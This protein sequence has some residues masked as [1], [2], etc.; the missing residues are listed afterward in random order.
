MAVRTFP[1]FAISYSLG[2]APWWLGVAIGLDSVRFDQ[3]VFQPPELI[4]GVL[5]QSV[6]DSALMGDDRE[7]VRFV[8]SGSWIVP[9]RQL[10]HCLKAFTSPSNTMRRGRA[11]VRGRASNRPPASR[12]MV[13]HAHSA[14]EGSGSSVPCTP[15][16]TL[17]VV[18]VAWSD[19][20][21][22]APEQ[23][24]DQEHPEEDPNQ[25][26]SAEHDGRDYGGDHEQWG[27]PEHS[28]PREGNI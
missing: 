2:L 16:P 15:A 20:A 18:V 8:E 3:W 11:G 23:P 10:R 1:D 4:R 13:R 12:R 5:G 6:N 19:V 25:P 26:G 7:T 17:V 28:C 22:A 24:G 14:G 21:A 27:Q 9:I